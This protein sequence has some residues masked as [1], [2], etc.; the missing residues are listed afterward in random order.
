MPARIEWARRFYQQGCSDER[1][2]V[3]YD[4]AFAFVALGDFARAANYGSL[5]CTNGNWHYC[6]LATLY[7]AE[8]GDPAVDAT[9]V[10][11]ARADYERFNHRTYNGPDDDPRVDR[12]REYLDRPQ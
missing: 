12:L 3:C 9:D 4:P 2:T 6:P 11:E 5:G 10:S 8:T 7:R 1:Y